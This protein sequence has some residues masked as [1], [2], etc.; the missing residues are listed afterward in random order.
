MPTERGAQ[1]RHL[2]KVVPAAGQGLDPAG[3][4]GPSAVR[5]R[6]LCPGRLWAGGMDPGLWAPELEPRACRPAQQTSQTGITLL[7]TAVLNG[8]GGLEVEVGGWRG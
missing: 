5:G 1:A 6:G 7:G 8:D 4:R 3:P 2:L